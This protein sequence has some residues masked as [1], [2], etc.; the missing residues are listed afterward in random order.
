MEYPGYSIYKADKSSVTILEDSLIVF[1]FL[2]E[3][4]KI[5][6]DNIIVF[7]LSIG[8]A[9]A[10]YLSSLRKPVSLILMS[11]FTSLQAAAENIVGKVIKF[12]VSE[13]Y[14]IFEFIG[15]QISNILK[16]FHVQLCSFMGN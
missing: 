2:T 5:D 12:L 8:S 9:P 7:G 13:R 11:P 14:N 6:P 15:S 4:L 1:D 16:V 3:S 10:T